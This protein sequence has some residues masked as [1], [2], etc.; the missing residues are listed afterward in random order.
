MFVREVVGAPATSF[1]ADDPLDLAYWDAAPLNRGGAAKL[2]RRLRPIHIAEA[3]SAKSGATPAARLRTYGY[4]NASRILWTKFNFLVAG[5]IIG[6]TMRTRFS[7]I[8]DVP[9]QRRRA[10]E[11]HLGFEQAAGPGVPRR[12]KIELHP[13]NRMKLRWPVSL[14]LLGLA[15]PC[16]IYIGSLRL[17]LY[18][19][20]LL[21]M[22]LPCF[23][24]LMSGKAGR[25][26]TVDIA[27]LLFSVWCVLSLVVNHGIERSAQSLGIVFIE[28]AGPYLLARCY[29][30][31]AD[32][33]YKVAQ[34][35]FGIVVFLL[36]FA[37]I[38]FVSGLNILHEMIATFCPTV[39]AGH[40]GPIGIN[41]G[42]FG[43]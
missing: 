29:V 8:R 39:S 18:R 12:R 19:I 11:I 43:L 37:I 4:D 35:L 40:A 34:L 28:T 16:A 10:S 13:A 3:I 30:R 1:A 21:A 20:V 9:G 25:I 5:K 15:W 32:A 23:G 38:E 41:T 22:V 31:D 33:F 14:F 6:S 24:I 42:T 7:S 26:R 27:V 2:R 17:S 36:P